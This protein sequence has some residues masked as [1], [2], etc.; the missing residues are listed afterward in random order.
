MGTDDDAGRKGGAGCGSDGG[1]GDTERDG[2]G[3]AGDGKG[4]KTLGHGGDF[5][6]GPTI[7]PSLPNV[8]ALFSNSSVAGTTTA[9]RPPTGEHD[10]ADD[11]EQHR[12]GHLGQ[13]RSRSAV[14]RAER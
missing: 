11:R 2:S 7:L 8:H 12:G 14:G 13:R 5:A 9:D 6:T 3:G 10:R 1:R 4:A